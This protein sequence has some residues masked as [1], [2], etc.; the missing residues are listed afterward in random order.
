[1]AQAPARAVH[2][3][4]AILRRTAKGGAAWVRT[5]HIFNTGRDGPGR[6]EPMAVDRLPSVP[7]Q[8]PPAVNHEPPAVQ[9]Q[10]P[11]GSI[12]S[13][14]A[15]LSSQAPNSVTRLSLTTKKEEENHLLLRKPLRTAVS[16]GL[17]LKVL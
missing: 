5:F 16:P 9:H 13:E 15:A 14:A 8:Q 6:H 7:K 4:S 2:D 17:G 12:R 11:A 3:P 1:M 10:L